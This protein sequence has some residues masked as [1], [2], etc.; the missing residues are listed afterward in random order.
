LEEEEECD[1]D[2]SGKGQSVLLYTI[3]ERVRKREKRRCVSGNYFCETK[4]YLLFSRVYFNIATSSPP[5]HFSL[6]PLSVHV[7]LCICVCA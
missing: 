4:A 7:F 2:S 1:D 3:Q 6:F 5:S